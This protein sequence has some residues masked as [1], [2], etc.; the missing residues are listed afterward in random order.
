MSDDLKARKRKRRKSK[1]QANA[2]P[3][4]ASTN[5]EPQFTVTTQVKRNVPITQ[6]SSSIIDESSNHR[7]WVKTLIYALIIV[8]LSTSVL[9][10]VYV[11]VN[12]EETLITSHFNNIRDQLPDWTPDTRWIQDLDTKSLIPQFNLGAESIM[13]DMLANKLTVEGLKDLM[14]QTTVFSKDVADKFLDYVMLAESSLGS[15]VDQLIEEAAA[16][17]AILQDFG[18]ATIRM[19]VEKAYQDE[20]DAL[21][22]NI[23]VEAEQKEDDANN[24]IVEEVPVVENEKVDTVSETLP[25]QENEKVDTVGETLPGQENEKVDTVGETLPDLKD[26]SIDLNKNTEE[27]QK[28]LDIIEAT[29]VKAIQ[30][31]AAANDNEEIVVV[32][33]TVTEIPAI[34]ATAALEQPAV[35]AKPV[36]VTNAQNNDAKEEPVLVKENDKAPITEEKDT[37]E[38]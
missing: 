10:G 37:I 5:E 24:D 4:P 12:D 19:E 21:T 6:S 11:F 30:E 31:N 13:P 16:I 33:A 17:A 7:S 23:H 9:F 3:A 38:K 18:A 22:D 32:E 35:A 8:A 2:K 20:R 34:G 26:I 25:G 36:L 1:T 28:N 29:V 27:L 15:C 14:D